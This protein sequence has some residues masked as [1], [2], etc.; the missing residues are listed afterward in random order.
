MS[1]PY[2][3][4]IILVGFNFAPLGYALCNGQLVAIAE[5]TALFQLLGTQ[6]GG[7]GVNTFALPDLRGRVP[8][9]QGQ[10]SG[11]SSYVMGQT[12]GAESVTLTAGQMP[13]HTH[14]ID[15]SGL[16]AKAKSSSSPGDRQ[17][18]VGNVPAAATGLTVPYGSGSPNANM[19]S[20]AI[21]FSG[22]ITVANAG[23]G[24]PHDNRQPYLTLNFCIAT[25][26]VFPSQ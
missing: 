2:I 26:G 21:A 17:T 16:T 20:G 5:N 22:A 10:G 25:E 19:S 11:L 7:D 15:A 3:G 13:Q 12:G 8:V 14:A 6:F 9:A 18:P 24:Q 4:Q 23:G 1:Q